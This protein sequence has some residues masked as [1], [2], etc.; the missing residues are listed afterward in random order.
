MP[1]DYYAVLGVGR[2]ASESEIKSA[3]R[4]L[5]RRYHPDVAENKTDADAHFKEINE[6]YE[7]LS[8]PHKRQAYD[9]FGAS[10]GPSGFSGGA[11]G[12]GPAEGFGDIFDLFFNGMRAGNARTPGPARGSDLRYDL[13]IELDEAFSGVEREISFQSLVSCESCAGNGARPGTS[14]VTCEGCGGT[15]M[16][17]SIRQS[18]LGQFVTQSPCARCGGQG[19]VVAS[20]CESCRGRGCLERL[21]TLTVRI[22]AGVDDGSSIRITGSGEAGTR[23]GPAG[24]LYVN[25]RVAAH[26]RFRRDGLDLYVDQ[27]LSFTQA[28]LGAQVELE[29]L[30]GPAT[31]TVPAGTQNGTSF[32]VRGRGM[33]SVRGNGRGDVIVLAHVMV[34]TRLSRKERELLEEFARLGGDRIDERTFIDRVK[35]AFRAD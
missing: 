11:G 7:V 6:A 30:D 35:D 16:M 24:D 26:S 18:A 1:P 8:D 33:P 23:G 19:R 3:Y 29:T 27:P 28:A 13:E 17:R 34:P 31:L 10:A 4:S 5:A 32:R 20:P 15:G 22:P 12:F 2:D 21:R 14:A 25:L 9:R